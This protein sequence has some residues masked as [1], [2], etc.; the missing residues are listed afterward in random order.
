MDHESED[1]EIDQDMLIEIRRIFQMALKGIYMELFEQNQ[2]TPD[3][4]IL[5]IQSANLDLDNDKEPMNS[6]EFLQSQFSER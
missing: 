2:C 6:W 5:L 1:Q 3:T 4:I